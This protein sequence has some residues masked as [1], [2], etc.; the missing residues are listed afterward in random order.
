MIKIMPYS[1]WLTSFTSKCTGYIPS[2]QELFF[3]S[4]GLIHV[5]NDGVSTNSRLQRMR[6]ILWLLLFAAFV[7]LSCTAHASMQSTGKY[8]G[9]YSRRMG[10]CAKLV[11]HGPFYGVWARPPP[12]APF[13]YT[14]SKSLVARLPA[15]IIMQGRPGACLRRG[16]VYSAMQSRHKCHAWCRARPSRYT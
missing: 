7:R 11:Y 5:S 14:G 16:A 9:I 6:H 13:K 15:S 2:Q 4:R 3:Q 10:D 8:F 1:N 12:L